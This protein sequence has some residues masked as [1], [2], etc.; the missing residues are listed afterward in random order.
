[1]VGEGTKTSPYSF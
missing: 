1:M